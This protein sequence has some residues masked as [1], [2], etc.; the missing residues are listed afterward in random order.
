M[1]KGEIDRDMWDAI[2]QIADTV[3][4][5]DEVDEVEEEIKDAQ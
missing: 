2:M 4:Y 1:S 5:V 3:L